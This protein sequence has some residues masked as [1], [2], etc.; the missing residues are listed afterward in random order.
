MW[1]GLGNRKRF[2]YPDPNYPSR[3]AF[4]RLHGLVQT[5][6]FDNPIVYG[7]ESVA[8]LDA[9]VTLGNTIRDQAADDDD[10]R[11][12]VQR[13]LVVENGEAEATV[14]LGQLDVLY[15]VGPHG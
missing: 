11:L 12:L 9:P 14:W 2:R 7:N 3:H 6:V 1:L 5:Y 15:R 10:R 8:G 4:Q 13:V